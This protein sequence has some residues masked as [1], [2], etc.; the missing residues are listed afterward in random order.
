MNGRYC[1]QCG[2]SNPGWPPTRRP[3][4]R[5]RQGR[6]IAG[7]CLALANNMNADPTLIRVLWVVLSL[8]TALIFGVVAY[9]VAWILIPEEPEVVVAPNRQPTEG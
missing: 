9:F 6:K 4:E 7:V 5:P 3:L 2:R 8:M 1:H